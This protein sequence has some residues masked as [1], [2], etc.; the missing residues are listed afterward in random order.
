VHCS[1]EIPFHSLAFCTGISDNT[2]KRANCSVISLDVKRAFDA[3]WPSIL[4]AL[5]DLPCP[6]N[7][8]NLT[9]NYFSERSAFIS[10]NTM[11][12]DTPVN[13]GCP[14]GS[15]CGP[16][17]WNI[18]YN[19]LLNLNFAKWTRAM[20]FGDNLLIAVKAKSIAEVENC[21]NIEMSK[22]TKC[23]TE[24]ELNFN[25]QKLRVMLISR[26]RKE[27]KATDIPKQQSSRISGQDKV[28]RHNYGW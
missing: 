28:L 1:S 14:Q 16:G 9:K 15:C 3:W 17:Y 2:Y 21:M 12:L 11:Q 27:R 25:D 24:N 22:I 4:K 7:L 10:T 18:Q 6:R 5:K 13:K 19:S 23:S 26:R 20:A 8:Y